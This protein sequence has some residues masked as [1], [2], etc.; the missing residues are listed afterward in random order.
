MSR[1]MIIVNCAW[2]VVLFASSWGVYEHTQES[3]RQVG[4]L[5]GI[6]F[7]KMEIIEKLKE[8]KKMPSCRDLSNGD[9]MLFFDVKA[10]SVYLLRSKADEVRFCILE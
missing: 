4:Y 3:Y 10:T 7:Q 6:V 1:K 9:M 2:F 8:L 5:S